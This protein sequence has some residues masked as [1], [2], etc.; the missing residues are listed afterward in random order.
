MGNF[1]KENEREEVD[2]DLANS[3]TSNNSAES[4]PLVADDLP[5]DIADHDFFLVELERESDNGKFMSRIEVNTAQRRMTITFQKAGG[6]ERVRVS[7]HDTT[8]QLLDQFWLC[9]KRNTNRGYRVVRDE[10]GI[11]EAFTHIKQ[12]ERVQE[13]RKRLS[14][15]PDFEPAQPPLKRRCTT[16]SALQATRDHL[17]DV[18]EVLGL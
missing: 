3:N 15:T 8:E 6:A 12:C 9:L 16:R 7:S 13:S 14:M 10:K 4:T 5:A 11:A 18:L 1:G 17:P 2:M